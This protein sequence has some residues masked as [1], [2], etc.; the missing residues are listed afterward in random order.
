MNQGS[1]PQSPGL[2]FAALVTILLGFS[3]AQLGAADAPSS[4]EKQQNALAVLRSDAPP[5]EKGLACKQLA[6]YG[7]C[8]AVPALAPLLLNPELSSWARI[9]LEAIPDP[10]AGDALREALGRVQGRLAVGVINSIGVRRDARA[11][12]TLVARLKDPDTDIVG[13]AANAL[14]RIGGPAAT[15]ALLQALPGTPPAARGEVALGCILCAEKLLAG[16]D[17][18]AAIQV[19][20]TVRQAQVPKQR[21][22]EATRGAIL[23]RKSAGIPLLLEQLRSQNK[24]LFAVGLRTARELP[25]PEATRTLAAELDRIAPNRQAALAQ[26]LADR[27]DASVLPALTKV[28]RSGSGPARVAAVNAI[29]KAAG[30][31]GVPVL[32]ELAADP[33]PDLA[34]A[35][36]TVLARLP[37]KD[38]DAAIVSRLAQATGKSQQVLIE[39]AGARHLADALPAI[40]RAAGDSDPGVRSAAVS[41]LGTLGSQQQLGELIQLLPKARNDRERDDIETALLAISS[42]EGAAG[43]PVL[44]PLAQNPQPTHRVVGLHALAGAGGGE[45]LAAVKKAVDDPDPTVQDEAVRSLS[46]WANNWPEEAGLPDT[47]LALARTGKKKTHQVLALRGYLQWIQ[48]EKK[49]SDEA[50]VARLKDVQPLLQSPEDKRAAIAAASSIPTAD[51]LNLLLACA[52]DATVAEEACQAIASLAAKG[53]L[54]GATKETRTKALLTVLDKSRND[55]TRAK[56]DDALRKLR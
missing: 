33:Q 28:A 21:V 5:G 38:T 8:D 19:Y 37:G 27:G 23:A 15:Q 51:G 47:L 7:S 14:G 10:V 18:A 46:T 3:P 44:L 34:R 17:G 24:A 43:V 13:A 22:V 30:P 53:D 2:G 41:A 49:L 6:I 40:A 31:A 11:L 16:G 29:E 56:A 42:R 1:A 39:A 45:A 25:G 50:R 26:V 9:A 12:D 35:A 55:R 52:E 48:G 20:D 54:K 36:R 32:I 4:A